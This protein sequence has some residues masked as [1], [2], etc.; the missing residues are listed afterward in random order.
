[1]KVRGLDANQPAS[2]RRRERGGVVDHSAGPGNSGGSEVWIA[3]RRET[4]GGFDDVTSCPARPRRTA[5]PSSTV[6]CGPVECELGGAN[7]KIYGT[8]TNEDDE[9]WR[10]ADH[11][12]IQLKTIIAHDR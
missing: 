6:L 5:L 8:S 2:T 12:L 4:D 3:A 1:M 9:M 10:K 7:K 11:A